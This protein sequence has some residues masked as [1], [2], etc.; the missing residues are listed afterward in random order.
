MKRVGTVG[1]ECKQISDPVGD[2]NPTSPV[3]CRTCAPAPTHTS[4]Y[5]PEGETPGRVA[6]VTWGNREWGKF[7]WSWGRAC[8]V[9]TGQENCARVTEPELSLVSSPASS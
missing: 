8:V 3:D 2:T 7:H 4:S 6:A 5:F 1:K 9:D